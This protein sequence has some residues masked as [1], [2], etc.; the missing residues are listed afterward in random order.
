MALLTKN[1]TFSEMPLTELKELSE[2]FKFQE[3]SKIIGEIIKS[4]Q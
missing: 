1:D 3:V 2:K 4:Q